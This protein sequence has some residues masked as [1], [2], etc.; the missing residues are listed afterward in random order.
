MRDRELYQTILGLPAPWFVERVEL[1]ASQEEVQVFVELP[2]GSSCTCP[3]CGTACPHYD[4]RERRWRHLDT[5]QYRTILVAKVPRVTCPAHGILQIKV[6]WS[7]ARSQF[8]AL[9][10]ALVIDWLLESSQ[11]GVARKFGITWD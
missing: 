1:S 3:Q 2:A 5:C 11:T 6:P 7:D 10:E 8:T 4:H 9:F